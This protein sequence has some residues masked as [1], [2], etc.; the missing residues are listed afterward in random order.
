MFLPEAPPGSQ[1]AGSAA[2]EKLARQGGAPFTTLRQVLEAFKS[3]LIEETLRRFAAE[4]GSPYKEFV[5][6]SGLLRQRAY[7]F[8]EVL[9]EALDGNRNPLRVDQ[10]EAGYDRAFRG[11]FLGNVLRPQDVFRS[12]MHEILQALQ[13]Q[14]LL[15]IPNLWE[16]I[17]KFYEIVIEAY[18]Q[19]AL[20]FLRTREELINEKVNQLQLL[21]EFTQ[22]LLSE[23]PRSDAILRHL[24]HHLVKLF[25]TSEVILEIKRDSETHVIFRHPEPVH[26]G[27]ILPYLDQVRTVRTPQYTSDMGETSG[28]LDQT[29]IK[30]S[31]ILP[32]LGPTPYRGVLVLRNPSG[33]V[34]TAREF[35][36]VRQFLQISMV[37]IENAEMLMEVERKQRELQAITAKMIEIGEEERKK[38]AADIHDTFAQTLVFL[39]YRLQYCEE[40]IQKQPELARER[41]R[42]LRSIVKKA[43]DQCR[44]MISS[45]RPDLIDTLGLVGALKRLVETFESETGI[46]VDAHFS[47]VELSGKAKICLFRVAQEALNNIAKHSHATSVELALRKEGN[48]VC[49]VVADN[50][51]GFDVTGRNVSNVDV[52]RMGLIFMKERVE[53][54]GGDLLVCSQRGRGCRLEAVIPYTVSGSRVVSHAAD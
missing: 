41:F 19:N 30:L 43:A 33:F 15:N 5:F 36:L 26:A 40:E 28:D 17:Q 4:P 27:S 22:T 8:Y 24:F 11:F 45:L 14:G 20:S 7:T 46:D 39:H 37:A 38:L 50:G 49:L 31:A 25:E 1:A 44:V 52:G 42:E 32:V 21:Y 9:M 47:G 16:E 34:F 51:V 2:I 13:A 18:Q 54:L 12:V 10:A 6:K 35:N 3:Y 29:R 23:P 48:R 53:S